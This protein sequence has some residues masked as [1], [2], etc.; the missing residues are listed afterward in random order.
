MATREFRPRY[1]MPSPDQGVSLIASLA[2]GQ[3]ATVTTRAYIR[4]RDRG[5]K[6]G[7]QDTIVSVASVTY[8]DPFSSTAAPPMLNPI[9]AHFEEYALWARGLPGLRS[10]YQCTRPPFSNKATTMRH[11][12]LWLPAE[13]E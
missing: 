6:K 3:A 10:K 9:F 8:K 4:H 11:R 5:R 13:S 2:P 12:L 7:G 1:G